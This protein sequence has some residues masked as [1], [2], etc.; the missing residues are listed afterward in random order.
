MKNK[1]K[2]DYIDMEEVVYF[3]DENRFMCERCELFIH[4]ST[5]GKLQKVYNN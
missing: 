4:S 3:H 5:F 1:C 2:C